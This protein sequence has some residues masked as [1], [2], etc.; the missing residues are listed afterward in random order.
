MD[1]AKNSTIANKI[2]ALLYILF[3]FIFT[4]VKLSTHSIY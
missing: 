3:I 2:N 1:T 4:I